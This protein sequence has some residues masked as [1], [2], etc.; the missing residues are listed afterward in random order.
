MYSRSDWVCCRK[1]GVFS[2]ND[3]NCW[4]DPCCDVNR[5]ASHYE[6]N[7]SSW[8]MVFSVNTIRL[9]VPFLETLKIHSFHEQFSATFFTLP[10]GNLNLSFMPFGYCFLFIMKVVIVLFELRSK[11]WKRSWITFP[12][13]HSPSHAHPCTIEYASICNEKTHPHKQTL[14]KNMLY[15]FHLKKQ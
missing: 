5:T 13:I 3:R 2:Q 7:K 9:V 1:L 12:D 6:E 4:F 10:T 8:E 15:S 11:K 14:P